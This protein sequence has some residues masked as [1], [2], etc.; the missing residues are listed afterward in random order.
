MYYNKGLISGR[1]T[2]DP[3]LKTTPSGL[4]VATITVAVNRQKQ[5]DKEQETDFINC[6][7]WRQRADFVNQWFKKGDWIFVEGSI[8]V[9][10]Y[11]DKDGNKRYVT[12]LVATDARFV[13]SKKDG[14]SGSGGSAPNVGYTPPPAEDFHEIGD[15]DELPF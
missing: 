15:D 2:A 3:E 11:N 5:K 13:G 10:S 12:E 4:S 6:V 9:R 1:L 14:G 8:T 7:L